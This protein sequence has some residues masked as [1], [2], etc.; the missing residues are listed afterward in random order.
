MHAFYT[1]LLLAFRGGMEN[2]LC[3][4]E[5]PLTAMVLHPHNAFPCGIPAA[6]ITWNQLVQSAILRA[7]VRAAVGAGAPRKHSAS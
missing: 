1:S 4:S 7:L 6:I 5:V 3:L 2:C